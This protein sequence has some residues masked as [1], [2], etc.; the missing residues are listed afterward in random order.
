MEHLGNKNPRL[1][2]NE[3]LIAL[4]VCAVSDPVASRAMEALND[5]AGSEAHATPLFSPAPDEN[6]LSKLKINLTCEPKYETH[7]LYHG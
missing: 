5:L 3:A 4:A 7:K 1:H 2:V 6:T